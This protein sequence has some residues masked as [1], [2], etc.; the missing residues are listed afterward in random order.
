MSTRYDGREQGFLRRSDLSREWF[1][2]YTSFTNV[3]KPQTAQ[4]YPCT[5]CNYRTL[6]ERGGYDICPVCLWEDD[7]RDDHDA[8]VVRGG[9]N[10]DLSLAKA[11]MN[12]K[13][14]GAC[15]RQGISNVRRPTRDEI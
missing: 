8:D 12:F 13:G 2:R 15:D 11:R 6:H 9:P 7:G 5:C 3:V 10:G 14:F 4:E 1:E